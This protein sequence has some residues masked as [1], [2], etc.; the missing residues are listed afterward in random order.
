MFVV[1]RVSG[2]G[3]AAHVAALAD[4]PTQHELT[5]NIGLRLL[6]ITIC[7]KLLMT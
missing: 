2:C 1:V 4:P 7:F 6:C 3:A 5:N